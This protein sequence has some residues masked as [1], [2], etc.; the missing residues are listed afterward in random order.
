VRQVLLLRQNQKAALAALLTDRLVCMVVAAVDE[1]ELP[2]LLF[3]GLLV[4]LAG[5][6]ARLE[7]VAVGLRH[8]LAQQVE[9]AA[10][11][12]SSSLASK[13]RTCCCKITLTT[14]LQQA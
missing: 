14:T 11:A 10:Q 8:R 3:L 7:V 12:A 5:V 6:L 4:G 9:Q 1:Q 2:G 13:D